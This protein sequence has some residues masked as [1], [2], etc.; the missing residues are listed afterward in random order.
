ML[1]PSGVIVRSLTILQPHRIVVLIDGDGALFSFDL[2]EQ[3]Q[4][5]GGIA[6]AKIMESIKDYMDTG[7][8][9]E[10]WVYVFLNKRGLKALFQRHNKLLACEQ[11]EDFVIGMNEAA[12]TVMVVDVGRQKEAADS[13]IKGKCFE[14]AT[15]GP[16]TE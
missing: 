3:G 14:A 7:R 9:D 1:L 5:G 13:K 4:V 16:C 12:K 2:I 6:A 15:R 11:L 10:I 8:R